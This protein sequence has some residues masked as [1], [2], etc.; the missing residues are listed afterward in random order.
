MIYGIAAFFAFRYPAFKAVFGVMT[1][2]YIFLVPLV[3]GC[4][5][6]FVGEWRK[7]RSWWFRIFM[8][9]A[10]IGLLVA[11][12][13]IFAWEGAICVLM[14][15]PSFLIMASLGGVFYGLVNDIRGNSLNGF[16]IAALVLLPFVTAPVENRF[17]A[18]SDYRSVKTEIDIHSPA[19]RVWPEIIEVRRFRPEE[20]HFS[21]VHAI[22]F[23]RPVEATLS[24]PGIGGIRKASFEGNVLFLETIDHWEPEKSLSFNIAADPDSIPQTTLDEHVTV[25]GPFFDV[26]KGQYEIE[27]LGPDHV[28]LHLTSYYRLTTPFNFYSSLWTDF[29]MRDIQNY[30]L[31]ILR[32]RSE[33]AVAGSTG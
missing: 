8:P 22:G 9:W 24:H 1:F 17:A 29:V 21:W 2:A 25:G 28:R 32:Q 26:L 33:Q 3:L 10:P 27:T 14:I 20:Q 11:L 19:S 4:I 12:A 7:R 18:P 5:T 13:L 16:A 15:L 6:V 31:G 23:P 30:I